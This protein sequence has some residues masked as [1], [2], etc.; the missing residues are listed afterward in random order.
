MMFTPRRPVKRQLV[1]TP[2]STGKRFR[3][4]RPVSGF[5]QFNRR[6][7]RGP[8]TKGSLYQQVK[9]LQTFARRLAP[10]KKF[11]DTAIS[12]SSIPTAGSVI[13]INGIGE[14]D[15]SDAR[16]GRL[17]NVTDIMIRG[18]LN[19][20]TDSTQQGF[21]RFALVQDKQQ[22]AD[23]APTAQAIF[24][25]GDEVLAFPN[26]ANISRFNVL[27]MS[28]VYDLKMTNIDTDDLQ[29]RSQSVV[30][31]GGWK[32]NIK[33]QFNGVSGTDIE[34]NGLYFVILKSFGA[35]TTDFVGESRVAYTDV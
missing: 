8:K 9:S 27:W 21:V 13:L 30:V 35:T 24:K 16:T 23:T 31:S 14:N 10:E 34:K 32:G 3:A 12:V 20:D 19:G 6:Y 7:T 11:L 18:F 25:N 26:N 17:V 5:R 1:F 4:S 33:T 29:P 15:T 28:K 22:V 2:A